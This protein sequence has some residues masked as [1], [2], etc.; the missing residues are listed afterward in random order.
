MRRHRSLIVA[1]TLARSSS[2]ATRSSRPKRFSTSPISDARSLLVR[3]GRHAVDAEH[4]EVP[5]LREPEAGEVRVDPPFGIGVAD[6]TSRF[7]LARPPRERRDREM[8]LD[9]CAVGVAVQIVVR[10][11]TVVPV[12][13][14]P[15]IVEPLG[16]HLHVEP[17]AGAVRVEPE[18]RDGRDDVL[19]RHAAH[20]SK[21][22]R[23]DFG[24][25]VFQRLEERHALERA[26]PEGQ[27]VQEIAVA[28]VPAGAEGRAVEC[29]L[30][31]VDA[32]RVET[33]LALRL[34]KNPNA[35]PTSSV[36]CT[37][38]KRHTR[39]APSSAWVEA[40]LYSGVPTSSAA[41]G[42]AAEPK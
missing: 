21:R 42:S 15:V 33:E 27:A 38:R 17:A 29:V 24:R 20:L 32:A 12:A 34:H 2:A 16:P 3:R 22:A 41:T 14:R 31:D 28:D 39:Y 35:Q 7:E 8:T 10:D 30:A 5:V 9:G 37:G 6:E 26:P 40:R 19:R 13:E 1:R 18:R 36:R 11:G 23:H 25:Q 4:V